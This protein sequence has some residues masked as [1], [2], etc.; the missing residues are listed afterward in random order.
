MTDLGTLVTTIG[1]E[2]LDLSDLADAVARAIG[3][4]V[5]HKASGPAA[6]DFTGLSIYF[7]PA[8]ELFDEGYREI[9][10]T[11][12]E[13]L[14][15][16]NAYY[17]AGGDLGDAGA[18]VFLGDGPQVTADETGLT[19]IAAL[20]PATL[21]NVTGAVISYGIANAD[22]SVTYLG[23]E[24][25]EVG[26]DGAVTGF[27]DL[28]VLHLSDGVDEAIAGLGSQRGP[29]DATAFARDGRIAE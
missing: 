8:G 22:G 27:Y 13:W 12:A 23:E 29:S 20:D 14:S 11:G 1:V 7:P 3:G 9:P 16:L 6:P 10:E 2:A 19:A 17:G 26:E 15:F 21:G 4:V 25:A 24:Q 28:A 5:L 18:P